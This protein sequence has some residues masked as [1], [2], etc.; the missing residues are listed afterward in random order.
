L[1]NS[2]THGF[3]LAASVVGGVVLVVMAW[4]HGNG[5]HV[6][7]C[8]VFSTTLVLLYAAS[9]VYHMVHCPRKKEFFRLA[10]HSCIY[11]LIAGSY[12]PFT[13]TILRGGVGWTL[14]ALAWGLALAGITFKALFRDRFP[15]VSVA[16]YLAMGW[17]LVVFGLQPLLENL[18]SGGILWLV[19]GGLSYT[20]GV[21]FFAWERL[22]HNHAI[23]HL[24]VMGGS[25]CH[26]LA[27]M[28][29]LLPAKP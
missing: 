15:I 14:F 12:T 24:F 20:G 18:P 17:M 4:L 27:V 3:G 28:L 1:A 9:T 21:L 22:P 11:L 25:A 8:A 16:G 5:W 26:Y 19:V 29:Y 23:W 7:G 6:A 10:D 2:L 13:L